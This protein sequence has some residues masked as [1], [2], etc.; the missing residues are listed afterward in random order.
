[1]TEIAFQ[2]KGLPG[3]QG[4]KMLT[5]WGGLRESSAKVEPWRSAIGYQSRR[6]YVGD[7]IDGPVSVSIEFVFE[8]PKSH[9]RTGKYS[10][11]LREDA[12]LHVTSKSNGDIDKLCRSTLDGLSIEGSILKDDKNVVMLTAEKRYST[13]KSDSPGAHISIMLL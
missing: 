9:F 5:K 8:R 3:A 7:P 6:H 4:S 11:N 1:M 10:S 2:V 13:S 12:P